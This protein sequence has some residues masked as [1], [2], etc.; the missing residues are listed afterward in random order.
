M[1]RK[2]IAEGGD[3]A[4]LHGEL[5]LVLYRS[6]RF[7]EAILELGRAAQ[8]DPSTPEYSLKLAA[9]ILADRRY[10]VALEFLRSIEQTFESHAEYQYNLGL[11]Y[12]GLRQYDSALKAF[13][14]A[15]HIAPGMDLAHFFVANSYVAN[16]DA[17]SAIPHY[18]KALALN[19]KNAGYYYALG[20]T[21]G[22]MGPAYQREAMR[23]LRTALRLKPDDT[24]S[25]FALAALCERTGDTACALPLLE[26]VIARY[27]DDIAPRVVLARILNKLGEREKARQQFESI[28]RL[29]ASSSGKSIQ[30]ELGSASVAGANLPR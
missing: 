5:G 17:A 29:E 23:L 7:R 22:E 30:S 4:E 10:S 12:Y 6:N 19:S 3:T 26:S 27:P 15:A 8:L 9:S 20:K 18:R 21:L 1:L 24:A 13:Q 11:A 16:A 28:R 25:K 14:Q 2:A